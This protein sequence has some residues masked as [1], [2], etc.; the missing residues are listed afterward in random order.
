MLWLICPNG[1]NPNG[2]PQIAALCPCLSSLEFLKAAKDDHPLWGLFTMTE[3]DAPQEVVE[4]K[5][6]PPHLDGVPDMSALI[7][8]EGHNV[9]HNLSC[10]YGK[11]EIYT[12]ISKVLIAINPFQDCV[13]YTTDL[14]TKYRLATKN[15]FQMRQMPPHVFS[16]SQNA[17]YNLC[18]FKKNQSMIVCGE[19]GS[20]KTESAKHLM[21]YLAWT[22]TSSDDSTERSMEK[23]VLDA[24]PILESF[25]NAKTVLN[26]NSSRFGKFTKIVFSNPDQEKI[27]GS[28]IETYL[29]EKS[30][31][32]SQNPNERNYHVFYYLCT[33]GA[34][35]EEKYEEWQMMGSDDFFYTNQGQ[36]SK[37]KELRDDEKYQELM[38]AFGTLNFP[39][40]V[41]WEVLELVAGLLHLGNIELTA[42][43][44]D[45]A[46]I[47]TDGA[48]AG[49]ELSAKLLHV[50]LDAFKQR[51]LTQ[52]LNVAGTSIEKKLSMELAVENRDAITKA[53]YHGIFDWVVSRINHELYPQDARNP[54][55]K[56]IGILDVFGFEFFENNSFEQFCINF[57]NERLQQYF[58]VNIIKSEQELYQAESILWEPITVPDNGDVIS[59]INGATRGIFAILDTACKMPKGDGET[60]TANLFQMHKFH[61]RMRKV[62][63]LRNAVTNEIDVFNGFSIRHYAGLVTYNATEFLRKNKDQND[64]DTVRLFCSSESPVTKAILED[65]DFRQAREAEAKAAASAK[66]APKGMAARAAMFEQKKTVRGG[67]GGSGGRGGGRSS[68]TGPRK[69]ETTFK[70]LGNF[71]NKQLDSLMKTLYETEPYF[72]R[73]IKPNA[74]KG[75]RDFDNNYIR[76]QLECGGIIEALRILKI[77]EALRILKC[78]YPSR[79]SYDDIFERYGSIMRPTP[80]NLN[81]RD[82]CEAVLR[83]AGE[84]LD[85]SEFQLGLSKV[86]FRPG[87]QA[88]LEDLLQGDAELPEEVVFKIK[89]FLLNKRLQ[90]ARGAIRVHI[91]FATRLREQRAL[92][93][94]RRLCKMMRVLAQSTLLPLKTIRANIAAQTIQACMAA[95]FAVQAQRH[96]KQSALGIEGFYLHNRRR[97]SLV[98]E[99]G[100]RIEAKRALMAEEERKRLEREEI[101]RRDHIARAEIE[102]QKKAAREAQEAAQKEKELAMQRQRERE[103]AEYE[104]Q[105]KEKAEREEL[106]RKAADA[107]RLAEEEKAKKEREMA[108][109]VQS[110]QDE[111]EELTRQ[112]EAYKAELENRRIHLE[113]REMELKEKE[114][115]LAAQQKA[116]GGGMG[117]GVDQMVQLTTRGATFYKHGGTIETANT[118]MVKL[119]DEGIL[120]WKEEETVETGTGQTPHG[121]IDLRDIAAIKAGP[122]SDDYVVGDKEADPA[123]DAKDR[124]NFFRII[125]RPREGKEEGECLEL[126]AA[127]TGV[128]DKWITALRYCKRN[129]R[130]KGTIGRPERDLARGNI[131]AAMLT[132][133]IHDY[134]DKNKKLKKKLYDMKA[135]K[136]KNPSL[137][138][139][140]EAEKLKEEIKKLQSSNAKLAK[141][142]RQR[143]E[144]G[145]GSKEQAHA[146]M[147]LRQKLLVTQDQYA[148]LLEDNKKLHAQIGVLGEELQAQKM[149]NFDL[150]GQDKAKDEQM[151]EDLKRKI[152]EANV[153]VEKAE[154]GV[155]QAEEKVR[156][157]QE[158]I[159]VCMR[160]LADR[161]QAIANTMQTMEV[162]GITDRKINELTDD[163]HIRLKELH[164]Q[165]LKEVQD[166]EAFLL[167]EYASMVSEA[168]T[169]NE[170]NERLARQTYNKEKSEKLLENLTELQKNGRRAGSRRRG[171]PSAPGAGG[172]KDDGC[173]IS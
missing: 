15:K 133:E 171:A 42:D 52:N 57:A 32:V 102:R 85:R 146:I 138:S 118:V 67:S 36:A 43:S 80:P 63:R 132:D 105:Q 155:Q 99:I 130:E 112:I 1:S 89:I 41:Q 74:R 143:Q 129:I 93:R 141:L 47:V 87:K 64:P 58:N 19:S 81:K 12:S 111:K 152:V 72:V 106:E 107:I 101:L 48:V 158:Q 160:N 70:S 104:R 122:R 113:M 157:R 39:P 84:T 31:I 11:D 22:P 9:L 125:T 147:E 79:C 161:K 124:N 25:G 28:F 88:F 7:Y 45:E 17:Y 98:K 62:N 121:E 96:K 21:R 172:D 13:D 59:L 162:L 38:E 156:N 60:F 149:A 49:L 163:T 153:E 37:V 18:K 116:G 23:Q 117:T 154:S 75:P 55:L 27:V 83:N 26:W 114:E 109:A 166:A 108:E 6:N 140:E 151:Q 86:F 100:K 71:F 76:P 170:Q 94:V 145:G 150:A 136:E 51:L 90:R 53:V 144:S 8:L 123:I 110:F 34:L 77:I 92:L 24:N 4:L 127:S 137:V 120:R 66:S 61:P 169:L 65:E 135:K 103:A 14:I 97:K 20:G 33:P 165:Q 10:R 35:P 91:A 119:T 139:S 168:E 115:K 68:A 2:S 78:G 82:F 126:Q 3:E 50:P 167:K 46:E 95:Q 54:V 5:Q 29:L 56:W 69:A 44:K 148:H 128:R 164:T 30:R 159:R 40:E 16:V 173:T 73:C 131:L 134:K 142:A